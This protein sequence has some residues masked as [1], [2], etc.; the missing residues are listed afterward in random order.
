MG[1][2][3]ARRIGPAPRVAGPGRWHKDDLARG[4]VRRSCLGAPKRAATLLIITPRGEGEGLAYGTQALATPPTAR[5]LLN[6]LF[7]RLPPGTTLSV[8]MSPALRAARGV[9]P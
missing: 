1:D 8:H 9:L 5:V 4:F 7:T 3:A 2:V 6:Y